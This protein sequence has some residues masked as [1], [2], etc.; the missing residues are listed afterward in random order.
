MLT[1]HPLIHRRGNGV[2]QIVQLVGMALQVGEHP[3]GVDVVV[4]V[5]PDDL[6]G[7]AADALPLVGPGAQVEPAQKAHHQ[8]QHTKAAIIY[9]GQSKEHIRHTAH[10]RLPNQGDGLDG[11][12]HRPG[13]LP[14]P[15]TEQ[16]KQLPAPGAQLPSPGVAQQGVGL[17]PGA[18]RHNRPQAQGRRHGHRL[19]D[20]NQLHKHGCVPIGVG[21]DHNA[22][23]HHAHGPQEQE[24]QQ[25]I[26][27]DPVEPVEIDPLH[28]PLM[29]RAAAQIH[30]QQK[31]RHTQ[32]YGGRQIALPA[33][34]PLL[35]F[36]RCPAVLVVHPQVVV[37]PQHQAY[38]PRLRLGNGL[39]S[40][41]PLQAVRVEDVAKLVGLQAGLDGGIENIWIAVRACHPEDLGIAVIVRQHLVYPNDDVSPIAVHR[42]GGLRR[43]RRLTLRGTHCLHPEGQQFPPVDIVAYAGII[44]GVDGAGWV[45]RVKIPPLGADAHSLIPAPAVFHPVI[46]LDLGAILLGVA[47][48]NPAVLV[49][50]LPAQVGSP[51]VILG[52][53]PLQAPLLQQGQLLP[54]RRPL[55]QLH[56][57]AHHPVVLP[58]QIVPGIAMALVI[59]VGVAPQRVKIGQLIPT[60]DCGGGECRHRR[61]E[62]QGLHAYIF[63][64]LHVIFSILYPSPHTT[65]R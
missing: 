65:F 50:K 29:A 37:H 7:A 48:N 24:T 49:Q 35:H 3:M 15:A 52:L 14:Q 42:L 20:A 62:G 58:H 56:Q 4:G 57:T 10:H 9:R 39:R 26:P 17:A 25:H 19:P 12:P 46:Y 21:H 63:P 33:G 11:T 40:Q 41:L 27:G 45:F 31:G 23:P 43:V 8:P 30:R 47:V 13:Q 51:G 53:Q 6:L 34:L 36:E 5:A 55:L 64:P 32:H 44:P 38:V 22:D 54:R 16:H 2:A 18:H 60:H 1:L 59:E 61:Y 28:P